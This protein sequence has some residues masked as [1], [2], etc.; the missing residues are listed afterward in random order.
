MARARTLFTH[1]V[2]A[3]GGLK[4]QTIHAFAERLLQR[5]QLEAGVPPGFAI[6]DEETAARMKREAIDEILTRATRDRTAGLGEALTTAIAYAAEDHFDEVLSDALG[7][8]TWLEALPRL[9]LGDLSG[10]AA[11]EAMLK[12]HLG[13][14]ASASRSSIVKEQAAVLGAAEIRRVRSVLAEGTK[15]DAAAAATLAG[16][17]TAASESAKAEA[18]ADFFLTSIG[19]SRKSLMTKA[20]REANADLGSLLDRARDRFFALNRERLGADAVAATL[21]LSRLAEAVMQSYTEA[22]GR[23]AALDFDDLISKTASLL[24]V[25][26]STQWVLYKLDGGLDHILVDESQDTSPDQWRIISALAEEFFSGRGAR[27]EPSSLFAV[28]DEKQSIY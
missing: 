19:E 28:G 5:F 20:L 25:S 6:L 24:R 23:R 13:V 14:R 21:A 16:A 10:L 9:A 27:D 8:R 22:K 26:G 3:P 7:Y 1:A 15:T 12:T 18:L 4:V 2:E 17:L 11:F